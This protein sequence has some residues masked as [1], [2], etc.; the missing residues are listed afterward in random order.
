MHDQFNKGTSEVL[1]HL[2]DV[3]FRTFP[4]E[5]LEEARLSDVL[6]KV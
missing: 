3:L 5:V 6:D 4:Q 1:Y 2:L